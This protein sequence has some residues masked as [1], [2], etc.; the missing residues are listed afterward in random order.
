MLPPPKRVP[1]EPLLSDP[2]PLRCHLPSFQPP[3]TRARDTYSPYKPQNET[4]RRLSLPGLAGYSEAIRASPAGLG[5]DQPSLR[6]SRS[7]AAGLRVRQ[8][9]LDP[10][11]RPQHHLFNADMRVEDWGIDYMDDCDMLRNTSRHSWSGIILLGP[12]LT[13]KHFA[14]A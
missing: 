8:G 6:R 10:P 13:R 2:A 1:I 5:D 9:F 12:S 11:R 4:S 7:L 3:M 14:K